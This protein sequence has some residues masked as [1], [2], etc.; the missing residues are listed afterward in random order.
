MFGTASLA[1]QPAKPVQAQKPCVKQDCA[2]FD[3]AKKEKCEKRHEKL[4]ERL[5]LTEAQKVQAKEIRMKG[6]EKIKPVMVKI[7]D[8]KEA[9]KA[10]KESD[11]TD[12]EKDKKIAPLK[13]E[14]KKLKMEA[15]KI[16]EQNMKEFEAILTPE[17]KVEFEKIKQEGREKHKEKG[18]PGGCDKQGGCPVKKNCDKKQ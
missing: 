9:I 16:R 2:K 3:C 15:K 12:V 5:Q 8:K 4:D 14:M 1:A 11:L 18:R 7:K 13:A 6:H 17:Q 10:I